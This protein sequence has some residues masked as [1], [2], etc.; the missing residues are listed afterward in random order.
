[1]R[2][3][4]SALGDPLDPAC[5]A[6]V[7]ATAKLCEACGHDVVEAEPTFDA[8]K[9]WTQFTA[10]LAGGIAWALAD[11]SRRLDRPLDEAL[12]EPFVWAFAKQGRAQSAADHLLAVQD[13]QLQVRR[14]SRFFIDHDLWLTA[15]LAQTPVPLGTLV[16][17]GDPVELRRRTAKFN[18]YN[19]I[20]NATGQPA[21]SLPLHW[22]ADGLP[23]G[24][25]FT[26]R[27]GEEAT[28]LRLAAQLEEARPWF[29]RRP[30]VCA[31]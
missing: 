14:Y 5:K 23:V 12:F 26:A 13:V 25:L 8:M 20:A 7:E 21:I 16:F 30:L 2:G 31:Q 18:P 4:N 1:M 24:S 29:E 28:L 9:L 19:Y 6:A 3:C 10:V 11:W 27:Y 15:T 22:S 17:N